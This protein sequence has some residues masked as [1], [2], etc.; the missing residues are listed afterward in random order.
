ML[1]VE[2][3]KGAL[4]ELRLKV[5]LGNIG[6]L[7]P[8]YADLSDIVDGY[9]IDYDDGTEMIAEREIRDAAWD[10]LSIPRNTDGI[11]TYVDYWT[12]RIATLPSTEG[13][14]QFRSTGRLKGE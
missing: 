4:I 3:L 9:P 2:E 14:R 11:R 7:Y 1:V 8:L 6:E 13:G 5:D 10:W 12:A